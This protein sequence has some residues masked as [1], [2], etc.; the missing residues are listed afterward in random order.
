[1][2]GTIPTEK[3]MR[4]GID[5]WAQ[6]KAKVALEWVRGEKTIQKIVGIPST[7]TC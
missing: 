6:Y 7:R 5:R 2:T 3:I 4:F 1:M